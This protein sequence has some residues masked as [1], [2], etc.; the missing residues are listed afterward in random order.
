MDWRKS[1]MDYNEFVNQDYDNRNHIEEE[2]YY[3]IFDEGFKRGFK[4]GESV[5]FLSGEKNRKEMSSTD[6]IITNPYS[7]NRKYTKEREVK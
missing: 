7:F 1:N 2:D 3:L 5:G 4:N 6:G